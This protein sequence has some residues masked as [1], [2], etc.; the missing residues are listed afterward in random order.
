MEQQKSVI[1]DAGHGG[2]EP[3]A[4]FEGRK[5]KDDTLRLA[6]AVGEILENNGIRVMYT[7]TTDVYDTPLEKAMIANG[8]GADFFVSIH[9][10]AMPVPGT[11]K[12]AL[13]AENIQ[14]NLVKAGFDDLEVQERPGII[15]L[16]RT[17]M[18]AVLVEA[19]FL[20]HPEDNRIFDEQF[21][22]IAQG[23][24]DGILTTFSQLKKETEEKRYYQVQVGA[25][26]E[27]PRA[28]FLVRELAAK[29][30]P[31][32]LVYDDGL[33]KV[34][35]GAFLQMDNGVRME[36]RVRQAGYPTMLVREEEV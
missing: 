13:M 16:R 18:P 31:A 20:D 24:A 35:V 7:R 22:Q 23:I 33:Y 9:R 1:I 28:E 14:K 6:L 30:F 25:Y 11:G 21:D 32:F 3:G 2:A 4:M 36:Q 15:V 8:S 26:R 17:K 5:E 19:G 12:G 10:N 34:R 27:R 29:G